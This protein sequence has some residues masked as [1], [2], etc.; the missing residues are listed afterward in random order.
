MSGHL[1]FFMLF[2]V[3]LAIILILVN[4]KTLFIK[5]EEE[6][7]SSREFWMFIGVLVLVIGSLQITF[8]TSTPVI[9]KLFGSNLAPPVDPIDHYNRWQVPVAILLCLLIGGG[10]FFRYKKTEWSKYFRSITLSGIISLLI[11]GL[12]AFYLGKY[13]PHYYI[14][15]FASIFGVVA[16]LDYLF[17]V[18]KG[19][20]SNAGASIA[21]IGIALI[22][23]GALISNSKKEI[24]SSNMKNINLGKEIP[25]K[26]NIMIE[27][28]SDTL[29]MGPYFVSYTGNE[30]KGVNIYYNIRYFS[31]NRQSGKME[32]EFDLQP[33]VQLNERM[34]NVAEPAT[35]HFL[36]RDVYTH[37]TYAE[38]DNKNSNSEENTFTPPKDHMLAL[39]D[40]FVTSNSFVILQSLDKNVDR[41]ELHLGDSDLV[42][43]ARL[44]V[45]DVNK[46]LYSAEPLFLIKNFS[47]FTQE[48][49]IKELGLKFNFNK[50]DPETGKIQLSVSEN[51]SNRKDFVIMKAIIFPGINILWIG[52]ILMIIGSLVAL[53]KRFK[54]N[55]PEKI[56]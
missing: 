50:I 36:T 9:N 45:E 37:I 14:L 34:G 5:T 3:L 4:R 28:N 6:H 16:N 12:S 22:L 32:K 49:E 21:H 10:Q 53:L 17:R 48:A 35:K 39:G 7:F 29:Q 54:S 1:V 40:T 24:I 51:K 31:L 56:T 15:F 11:T 2:F 20:L 8:T 25:N 46:K 30:Q 55:V 47:I 33:L 52:C 18:L 44:L 26:E 23:C 38:L 13:P 42:V 19:K 27:R 41:K 43:G